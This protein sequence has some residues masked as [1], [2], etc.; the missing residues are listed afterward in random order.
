MTPKLQSLKNLQ[1]TKF[2]NFGNNLNVLQFFY[3][4]FIKY[5]MSCN[6]QK[7][8]VFANCADFAIS[9]NYIRLQ[10]LPFCNL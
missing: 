2:E 4:G 7:L 3:P 5:Q 1:F 9:E 6:F 8:K 10:C